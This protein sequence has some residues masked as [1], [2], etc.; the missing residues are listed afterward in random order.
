MSAIGRKAIGD[1]ARHRLRAVLTACTLSLALSSLAIA[2]IP[3]LMDRLMAEQVK[4]ARLYD[5]AVA[6]RDLMLSRAQLSA[7]GRLP[8]VD[9]FAASIEYPAQ[10]TADGHRQDATI[11]GINFASQP[12]DS[13]DILNGTAPGPGT[14]LLADAGNPAAAGMATSIGDRVGVRTATGT[15]VYLRVRGTAHSLATSPSANNGAG[16]PVF[17]ASEAT[18]RSLARIRGVNYLAFRLTHNSSSAETAAIAAIH[19]YLKAQTGAEPF[20]ALPVTRAQGDWPDRAGFDQVISFLYIITVLALLSAL[21]LVVTTM[22]TLVVEQAADIAILKTLGGRRR[23]IA[24]I[25]LRAAALLGV[26][27]AVAGTALGIGLAYLLT[28]YFASSFYDLKADF[29]IS[30]PVVAAS[31]LLGPA[32]AV[33]AS[34]PGLGRAL[35]RPVALA[36]AD[37]GAAGYGTG[38]IDRLIARGRLLPGP[39]RM[40]VRNILRSKRRSAATVAQIAVATG[41]AV[42]LYAGGQSV[43]AFVSKGYSHFRYNVEVDASNGSALGSRAI[44]IAAATPGVTRVEPLVEGQVTYAGR[45]Y[46]AWGLPARSLYAYRQR[47]PRAVGRARPGRGSRDGCSRRP[48]AHARYS[49]RAS[50]VRCHRDRHRRD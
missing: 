5:V 50:A 49:G 11:W 45:G 3:G 34:L 20:V 10:V 6:T 19:E 15:Q 38:R 48:G 32:L 25:V 37:R 31:L 28:S 39:A 9:G 12:V 42:A 40:G 46:A 35:R 8:N 26:L 47:G 41:L 30:V 23:Q 22:N 7:L 29:A 17:Y 21:F 2:A 13:V 33:L 18:V 43:G 1:L 36:L 44:A 14:Q 27:G 16:G 4:A 24:S